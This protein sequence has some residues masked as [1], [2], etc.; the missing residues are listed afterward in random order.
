MNKITIKTHED[1]RKAIVKWMHESVNKDKSTFVLFD[2]TDPEYSG[3]LFLLVHGTQE[4]EIVL[5]NSVYSPDQ[6]L[7]CFIDDGLVNPECTNVVYTISC[8]GGTQQS[9][10]VDNVLIQS[11]HQSTEMVYMAVGFDNINVMTDLTKSEQAIAL[12][13]YLLGKVILPITMAGLKI[14][15]W[16]DSKLQ[17]RSVVQK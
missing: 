13:R 6:I 10:L 12:V 5:N 17:R 15:S 2:S 9:Y 16:I 11:I 3:M 8:Y 7:R 1:A 14:G 4:G